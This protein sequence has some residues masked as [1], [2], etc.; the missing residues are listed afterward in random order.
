MMRSRFD[1]ERRAIIDLALAAVGRGIEG[2]VETVVMD[3]F[4]H[5]ASFTA[6]ANIHFSDAAEHLPHCPRPLMP[7]LGVEQPSVTGFELARRR[8]MQA[9]RYR[10]GARLDRPQL[11][12]RVQRPSAGE[13]LSTNKS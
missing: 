1:L 9:G 8:M 11:A 5:D 3:S 13:L 4:R 12:D 10:P 6:D 7:S 2:G